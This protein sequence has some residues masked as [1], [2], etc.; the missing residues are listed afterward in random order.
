MKVNKFILAVVFILSFI[1]FN[2]TLATSGACSDP[3][4]VNCSIYSTLNGN[5]ICNDGADS[6]V[7]YLSM[8]ECKP[9]LISCSQW[10]TGCSISSIQQQCADNLANARGIFASGGMGG[11][12]EAGTM[13]NQINADC[14][15]Q[16]NACQSEINAYNECLSQQQQ[17]FS[18]YNLM[19][20]KITCH[21]QGGVHDN[22]DNNS[23][24]CL[25]DAGYTMENDK[26]ITYD[27]SCQN[28]YG[29]N[30]HV[31]K[32]N[33]NNCKCNDGYQFNTTKKQCELIP[34]VSQPDTIPILPISSFSIKEN[35]KP[36]IVIPKPK[37]VNI[38]TTKPDQAD[39]SLQEKVAPVSSIATQSDININPVVHQKVSWYNRVL[40]LLGKIKFW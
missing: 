20:S 22:Y 14:Q 2:S 7:S 3:G 12:G 9:N 8:I 30:I 35:K 32:D 16:I 1:S 17:Q 10:A 18:Q 21:M 38:I 26:C 13:Q 39:I 23:K 31:D 19:L 40:N 11:S 29:L 5:A 25:C 15:N 37:S 6:T 36:S 28:L 34:A 27:Q 33:T 24:L 4:G